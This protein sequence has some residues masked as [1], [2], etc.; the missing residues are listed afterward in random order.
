MTYSEKTLSGN[1]GSNESHIDNAHTTTETEKEELKTTI[2]K[3][4]NDLESILNE[5]LRL[6][7]IIARKNIRDTA[8]I[9]RIQNLKEYIKNREI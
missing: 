1:M 4:Q 6:R 5:N 3:L 7:S 9:K 2:H 8:L